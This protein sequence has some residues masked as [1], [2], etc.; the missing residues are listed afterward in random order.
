MLGRRRGRKGSGAVGRWGGQPRNVLLRVLLAPWVSIYAAYND[1]LDSNDSTADIPLPRDVL[2]DVFSYF[3]VYKRIHHADRM[4]LRPHGGV[5][6]RIRTMM[7]R[8]SLALVATVLLAISS[9]CQTCGMMAGGG[10][11]CGLG[12]GAVASCDG[13]GG[14]GCDS[15]LGGRGRSGCGIG[16]G[17]GDGC[18]YPGKH[19]LGALFCCD[20]C[21]GETYWN[22]WHNDPPTGE[23]CGCHGNYIGRT[24][25]APS[26]YSEGE[27]IFE[28][29]RSGGRILA[30][31]QPGR[32]VPTT[33]IRQTSINTA[34]KP[35]C[36]CGKV[37]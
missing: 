15:C 27:I 7:M 35:A 8:C 22:E 36:S 12:G 23:P 34:A 25:G 14:G 16:G 19:L 28:G 9:G 21:G 11:S 37:H 24:R 31:Q 10:S 1:F 30:S 20:G 17:C 3:P 13:C 29:Q 2:G 26:H 18:W 5:C 4:T 32:P 33:A 6:E